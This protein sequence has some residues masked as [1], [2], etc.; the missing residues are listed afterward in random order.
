MAVIYY[1]V[2]SYQKAPRARSCES[3][4]P[5]VWADLVPPIFVRG[6]LVRTCLAFLL[7]AP[8]HIGKKYGFRSF[9]LTYAQKRSPLL[10]T[11]DELLSTEST[12]LLQS[13]ETLFLA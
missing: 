9:H 4:E 10:W 6:Y 8:F 7:L 3:T 13:S 1:I 5:F 11:N 12:N 2:L